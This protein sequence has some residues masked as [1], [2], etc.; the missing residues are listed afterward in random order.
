MKKISL[1]VVGF[2]TIGVLGLGKSVYAK[3]TTASVLVKSDGIKISET[4]NITFNDVTVKKGVTTVIEKDKSSIT[5]EDLR[6]SSSQGWTLTAKLNDE[7]FKGMRLNF[8][9]K[10][11]SNATVAQAGSSVDLNYQ[12][13]TI[14]TV[15]D[16]DIKTTDFDTN[17]SLNGKLTVPEK[18]LA[19][20]YTTTIVWNLAEGPGTI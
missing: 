4:K 16:T 8:T 3:E 20:T 19:T 13:Q 6:G 2:V 15:A 18:Q 12:P 10:I 14:A 1:A 9:P 11:E 7:N 5:I 17:V